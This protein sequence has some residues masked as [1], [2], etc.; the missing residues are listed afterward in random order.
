MGC[1]SRL[2]PALCGVP[3]FPADLLPQPRTTGSSLIASI[4]FPGKVNNFFLRFSLCEA[5]MG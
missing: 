5:A 4:A 2:R 1:T 3:S